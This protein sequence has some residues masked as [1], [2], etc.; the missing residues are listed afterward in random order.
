M[1]ELATHTY[2]LQPQRKRETLLP[3][4]KRGF[5]IHQGHKHRYHGEFEVV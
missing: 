3:L 1:K 2:L 5:A 4:L